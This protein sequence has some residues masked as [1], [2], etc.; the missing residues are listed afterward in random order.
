MCKRKNNTSM[1]GFAL[2]TAIKVDIDY[3]VG[4]RDGPLAKGAELPM[5]TLYNYLNAKQ[6]PYTRFINCDNNKVEIRVSHTNR[7]AIKDVIEKFNVL[8]PPELP[9]ELKVDLLFWSDIP[10]N[11]K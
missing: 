4:L 7:D 11:I 2:D 6:Y 10:L 1:F 5:I 3:V 9:S 8:V